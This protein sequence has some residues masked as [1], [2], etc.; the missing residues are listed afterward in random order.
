MDQGILG[1]GNRYD[2]IAKG[3]PFARD[4]GSTTIGQQMYRPDRCITY[5]ELALCVG[6]R[7]TVVP[8]DTDG[9]AGQYSSDIFHN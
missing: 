5:H 4:C 3:G 1:T 7:L 6:E 8:I 9:D 2:I